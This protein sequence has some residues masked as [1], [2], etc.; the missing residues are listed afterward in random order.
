[1]KENLEKYN[2]NKEIKK[3]N[4]LIENKNRIKK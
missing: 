3:I 4:K 1:M 2:L